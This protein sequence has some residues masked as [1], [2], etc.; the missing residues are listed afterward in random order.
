MLSPWLTKSLRAQRHLAFFSLTV[1]LITSV[2]LIKQVTTS[3]A[4]IYVLGGWQPP[5]GIMLLADRL[6]AM[7]V[8]LTGFLALCAVIYGS[9]YTETS[10]RFFY[11]L[12][13]FQVM[14][15]NGAFLTG[16][17]FNLFV[18]FEVLLI[19][20]YALLIHGGGKEKTRAGVQYVTLNLIGS[21][22]FL[23]ALGTLY[24]TL[25][26]LNMADMSVRVAE[27][28]PEDLAIAK[29]GALLLL[30]VF[31]LKSA[32]MPLQFWLSK[33]YSAASAPV[34]ALF[35]I[36]T[37]VGLYAIYR[38]FG[39]IFGNDAG[40][41]ANLGVDWIWPLAIATLIFSML[42]ALG[43]YNLRQ[44]ATQVIIMSVG[45]LL[46]TFVINNGQALGAG[47]YY[48]VHS[49]LAAAVLFLLA[50][51]I[52]IQRGPAQDRFVIA[53]PMNQAGMIST[54]YTIAAISV[55]GLP[56]LSGFIGKALVL[57][58]V[59]DPEEQIRVWPV[60]LFSSL[61]VMIAFSRAGTALFW[62]L[63]GTKPGT[64]RAAP[65]Q[66]IA[67]VLLLLATP[68]L[69]I[70]AGPIT[71]YTEQAAADIHNS[72]QLVLDAMASQEAIEHEPH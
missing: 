67:I 35:A 39:G 9:S 43:A 66:V 46:L 49:T 42:G 31:G 44:L 59:I 23:F 62:H 45:T 16:D 54:F 68:L 56:P 3:G 15:I 34:A 53:R 8:M 26:T 41:L 7:M 14:G 51:Q 4:M 2:L 22:F 12:F 65:A 71:A 38:V 25:G 10:G 32:M 11:P 30:L 72:T 27:L 21:A 57:K 52:Q 33:T 5:F 37:K 47:L 40:A 13:M 17:I 6:A 70:F 28:A 18:F 69:T 29:A 55:V 19:A 36:M 63:S 48:L 61:L 58:S 20:S 1:L 50:D 24:G 60:I 64:E